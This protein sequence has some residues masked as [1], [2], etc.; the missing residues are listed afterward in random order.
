MK[1]TPHI[2]L[3]FNG[4]CREAFEFY[5]RCLGAKT[6][7]MLT[8]EASPMAA[9]APAGWGE[10]ILY[11]RIAIGET[12]VI[13]SDVPAHQ[14]EMPKGFS[15][16]LSMDDTGE[17]E[18]IF[19]ALSEKGKVELPIQKTFWAARYGILTDQFG[20][21]WEINCEQPA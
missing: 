3:R 8:W 4:R 21:P 15:I 20:I 11:G 6:S 9:Q 16:L 12:D 10:K 14:Y 7:F 2:T 13:G 18:R 5:E 1:L 17:A 19:N